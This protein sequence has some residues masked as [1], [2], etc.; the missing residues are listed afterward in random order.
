MLSRL[1]TL[2]ERTGGDARPYKLCM[3]LKPCICAIL[4][5]LE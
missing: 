5:Y 1:I 3:R 2:S 4:A